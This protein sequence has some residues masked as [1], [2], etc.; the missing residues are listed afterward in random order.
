LQVFNI[1]L[2]AKI[3]SHILH[4]D[5]AFWKWI[6]G[7]T[8]GIVT[9]A[10]VY[11]WAPRD[12]TAAPVKVFDRNTTLSGHQIINYRAS[13]DEKW[14]V[15]IGINGNPSDPGAFKVEGNM[16]LYNKERGVSQSIK[17]H[18]ACFAD[19]RL[20]GAAMD[21]KLFAF[22]VRTAVGAEVR[23][24]YFF[25]FHLDQYFDVSDHLLRDIATHY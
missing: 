21:S 2:K 18:A 11:N 15:M 1:E 13:S 14:L 9:E 19:F 17:G 7:T 24:S 6:N 12:P 23:P 8:L 10:S 22:A 5:V 16:Q 25:G 4:E 3:K 20:D